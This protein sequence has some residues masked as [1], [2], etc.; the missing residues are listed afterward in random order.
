MRTIRNTNQEQRGYNCKNE[1][2]VQES[3]IAKK[4]DRITG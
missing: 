4:G 1:G 3:D 2:N